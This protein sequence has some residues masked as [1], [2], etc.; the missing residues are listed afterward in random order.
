[1][2]IILFQGFLWLSGSICLQISAD[3]C[4]QVMCKRCGFVLQVGRS[5]E[6]EMANYPS[7]LVWEIPMHE[8]SLQVTVRGL[9][10][11]MDM[12]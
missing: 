3:I 11:E 7:I 6:E 8:R 12:T 2:Y 10:K 9:Q 5:L 4:L 1:M